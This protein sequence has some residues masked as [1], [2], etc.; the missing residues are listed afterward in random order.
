MNSPAS[1]S[2]PEVSADGLTLWFAS[3]RAG[4]QGAHDIWVSTRASR[5]APWGAP[6]VVVELSS[7]A[8]DFSPAPTPDLLWMVMSSERP[9]AG[10]LD[11]FTTSRAVTR[12]AWAP[13]APL[14]ELDTAA[15]EG[16]PWM[17]AGRTVV[18]FATDRVGGQ[19]ARDIWMA[20]R[21]DPTGPFGA[22]APVTEI[23][24][25]GGD[26]DPWLSPDLRTIYFASNRA[27]N[28][29]LYMATR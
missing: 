2:T 1:D 26:D 27:G 24:G 12:A 17:D 11:L 15:A 28:F 6:A 29:D 5:G 21:P 10:G 20:E 4:G 16:N 19:G 8:N 13:P 7:A 23:N 22:A 14:A 25:A 3:D 18:C 9:G